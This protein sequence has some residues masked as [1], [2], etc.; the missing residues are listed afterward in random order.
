MQLPFKI[1]ENDFLLKHYFF[2]QIKQNIV[3]LVNCLDI[4][5][6]FIR[7]VVKI[8]KIQMFLLTTITTSWCCRQLLTS[9]RQNA[10]SHFIVQ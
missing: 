5:K 6:I 9:Y 10:M 1:H 7:N 2:L 4:T 8:I 3:I